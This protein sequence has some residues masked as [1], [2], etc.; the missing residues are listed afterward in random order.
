MIKNIQPF[1]I[2][3]PEGF[4]EVSKIK[5]NTF[6][7]YDFA[8]QTGYIDYEL[9]NSTNIMQFTGGV[10]IP[11]EITQNWGASDDIIFAFIAN[12]L[13]INYIN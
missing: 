9:L 6:Y 8:R 11:A 5:I 12:K 1:Q 10:F 3:S 13:G 7:N 2:W 4:I